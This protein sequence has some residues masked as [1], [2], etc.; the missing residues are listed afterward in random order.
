MPMMWGMRSEC[1]DSESDEVIAL[2]IVVGVEAS[3]M[4]HSKNV[5]QNG[6]NLRQFSRTPFTCVQSTRA[7]SMPY[8]VELKSIASGKKQRAANCW[9]GRPRVFAVEIRDQMNL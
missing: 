1:A 7:P 6:I 2:A 3:C 5:D 9:F 4:R 8:A